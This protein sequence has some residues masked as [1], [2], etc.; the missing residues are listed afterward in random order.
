LSEGRYREVR[1]LFDAVGVTVRR[2]T[3]MRFGD[4]IRPKFVA[5]GKTLEL[6]PAE[7]K[8]LRKSVK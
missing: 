2:L 6:K 3:R 1:R 7:V 5:R 4:I 8:R